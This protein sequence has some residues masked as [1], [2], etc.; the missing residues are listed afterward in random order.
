MTG[1]TKTLRGESREPDQP[2][3][4]E[5]HPPAR[6]RAEE[7]REGDHRFRDWALI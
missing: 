4:G 5:E 7:P 1:E 6:D 3:R 2:R